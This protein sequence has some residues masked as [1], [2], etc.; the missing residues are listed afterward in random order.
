[1]ANKIKYLKDYLPILQERFPEFS[2]ED[3]TTIIKYGN[4]YLYYVISNNSDVYLSSKID[5]KMFKFLIGRVTFQS[6]AHKIRYAISKMITKMRFLYRQRRTK[7]WGYCYFGLTEEKFKSIYLNKRNIT[8]NFGDVCLYRVLDECLLNLNYDHF[9]RV[10]LYGIPGYKVFFE[11]YS[12]K[13]VEY[14]LKR[15]FDG[16]EFTKIDNITRED[17]TEF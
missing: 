4:R 5:G 2:I 1:M 9:F 6:I 11:N 3:L 14:F 12:T 10:K 7:W 17:L 16:Y 15:S 13:D 8:F